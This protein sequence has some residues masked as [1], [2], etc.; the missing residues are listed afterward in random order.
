MLHVLDAAAGVSTLEQ[1]RD[2]SCVGLTLSSVCSAPYASV[3]PAHRSASSASVNCTVMQLRHCRAYRTQV[4]SELRGAMLSADDPLDDYRVVREEL[5]LYNPQYCQ[6]PHV[7]AL[8][9]SDLVADTE[10]CA[11]LA[12]QLSAYAAGLKVSWMVWPALW[13]WQP[14]CS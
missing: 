2:E 9:K 12:A 11:E 4:V 8:N 6:R 7:V 3:Q 13:F 14:R 10:R 1:G 5:R